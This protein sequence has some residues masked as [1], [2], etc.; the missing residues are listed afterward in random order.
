[1]ESRSSGLLASPSARVLFKVI[2]YYLVI[3]AIGWLVLN[4]LPARSEFGAFA[5]Q[6]VLESGTVPT[7][8]KEAIA[9]GISAHPGA[10]AAVA[11]AMIAAI[12]LS[13]P[14]AWIY[15]LTRAKR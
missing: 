7:S 8:K 2:V 12:V 9:A 3:I 13:L 4:K 14:V 5:L 11:A 1:M 6:P 10:A 15:Q